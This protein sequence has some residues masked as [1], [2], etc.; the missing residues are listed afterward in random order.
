[1]NLK[2]R[3]RQG[4]KPKYKIRPLLT[5]LVSTVLCVWPKMRALFFSGFCEQSNQ[6]KVEGVS[7]VLYQ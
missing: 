6:N 4:F 1:M 2:K 3:L 7:I 5:P